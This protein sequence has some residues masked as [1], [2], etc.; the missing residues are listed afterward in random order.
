MWRSIQVLRALAVLAVVAFHYNNDL[1]AGQGGVDLFFV[2]SGFIMAHVMPGK[3]PWQFLKARVRRIVPTYWAAIALALVI[4]PLPSLEH[5]MRSAFLVPGSGHFFVWPAW[6]LMFEFAFYGLCVLFLA[7]RWWAVAVP[8]AAFI[9]HQFIPNGYLGVLSDPLLIE[10][11][12]G[13]AI[14]HLPKRFSVV[15]IA[16]A[17]ALALLLYG[18]HRVIA[19]GIPAAF[20]VYGVTGKEGWFK[21]WSVP[22]LIGDASY[23]IYLVHWIVLPLIYVPQWWSFSALASVCMGVV[24]WRYVETPILK[25]RE[26]PKMRLPVSARW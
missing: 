2:I 17:A 26:W 22:V 12:F 21:G 13:V 11:A 9:A 15:S 16:I 24:F 10:F 8:V 1:R 3:R 7:V 14:Y 25:F 23:S 20:L 19:Y 18:E 6:T 5:F 4:R